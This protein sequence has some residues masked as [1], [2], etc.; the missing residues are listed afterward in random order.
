METVRQSRFVQIAVNVILVLVILSLLW[1]L[2]P[3]WTK[4]WHVIEEILVPF[5]FGI[6]IAYLLHPIVC[7]LER[8]RVP[9]M[10]AVLLIYL[11]FV[12][13]VVIACVNAIPVFTKQLIELSDDIPRLTNW[14]HSWL[15]EWEYHKYFLPQSISN[16]VDRVIV[17][18]QEKM[19]AGIGQIVNNAKSTIGKLLAYA[20]IPFIAF[21]LLKDMKSI[22]EGGMLIIPRRY[23]KH[24]QALL[25]DVNDSL[26]K[27]LH[28]QM[29][30]ALIV[31]ACAYLAYWLVDMPYPFVLASFVCL[32]NIIPYIGPIIGAA[33][34]LVIAF[35]IS[36]KTVLVVLA[37][38]LVIQVL[39]GNIISPNIVGRSLHLHPLLIILALLTGEAIGGIVGLIVALPVL[40]ILKVVISRIA[41]IMR[42]D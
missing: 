21:Y 40:A 20:V 16:G 22:H 28:G 26:G 38:N 39:E 3:I 13:V 10:V 41:L 5:L 25:R 6:L 35:T 34:A 15:Q 33:P 30:V 4:A 18:S 27:Y 14:Y 42:E 7:M 31:G 8:R 29:V 1:F 12:L 17:Q 32:T 37:V 23:R 2:R 11:S 24:A 9:R 36:T 19:A